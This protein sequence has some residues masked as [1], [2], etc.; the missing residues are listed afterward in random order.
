MEPLVLLNSVALDLLEECVSHP[1]AR[2]GIPGM[3]PGRAGRVSPLAGGP[4]RSPPTTT[5][6]RRAATR[7]WMTGT[8]PCQPSAPGEARLC[9]YKKINK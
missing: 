7:R 2:S 5:Q 6:S 9:R 4:P 8:D 3:R 1:L